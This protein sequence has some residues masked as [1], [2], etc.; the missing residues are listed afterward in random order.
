MKTNL[1][2]WIAEVLESVGG[3]S[4]VLEMDF[5]RGEV[6]IAIGM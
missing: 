3:L 6:E 5:E 1:G 2:V 4:K